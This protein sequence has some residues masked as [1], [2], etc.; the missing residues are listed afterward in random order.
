MTPLRWKEE[1]YSAIALVSIDPHG[2]NGLKKRTA[3]SVTRGENR[4]AGSTI[5]HAT[6]T[7]VAGNGIQYAGCELSDEPEESVQVASVS[8]WLP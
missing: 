1:E 8:I 4:A 7:E 3:V 5:E 2:S 6:R